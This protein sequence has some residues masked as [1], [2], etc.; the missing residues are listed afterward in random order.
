MNTNPDHP[1][2]VVLVAVDGSAASTAALRWA[3]DYATANRWRLR[4]LTA[5]AP[6]HLPAEAVV[7]SLEHVRAAEELARTKARAAIED[8]MGADASVDHIVEAG[9][10]D[11]VLRAAAE[12]AAMVVIGTR[13]NTGWRARWRGSLTNRITGSV[14]CPVVSVTAAGRSRWVGARAPAG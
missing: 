6:V 13:A 7:H 11:S 3:A 2:P 14:A 4:V 5:Y 8:V 10:I 9:S 1:Q 12:H